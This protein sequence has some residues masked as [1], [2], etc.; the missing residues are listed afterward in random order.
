MTLKGVQEVLVLLEI[1][2]IY[3]KNRKWKKMYFAL[4]IKAL[5]N[6]KMEKNKNKK[7]QKTSQRCGEYWKG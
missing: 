6:V 5:L 2:K 7:P 1:L 4:K 3:A